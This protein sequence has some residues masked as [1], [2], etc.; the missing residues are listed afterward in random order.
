LIFGVSFK[1]EFN[2]VPLSN[3]FDAR[4]SA[5]SQVQKLYPTVSSVAT[6]L[7][8]IG[9]SS[10]DFIAEYADSCS[11]LESTRA[12]RMAG[13]P[14]WDA[15]VKMLGAPTTHLCIALGCYSELKARRRRMVEVSGSITS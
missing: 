6:S 12:Y 2:C 13:L 3:Y 7:L 11:H 5:F 14:A 15:W 8:S 4:L 1:A 9:G 10:I